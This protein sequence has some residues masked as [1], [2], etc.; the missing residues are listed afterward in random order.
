[1]NQKLLHKL[2]NVLEI[3]NIVLCAILQ[4]LMVFKKFG[5]KTCKILV[6]QL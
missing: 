2:C 3:A 4:F 6:I 5:E 1:M